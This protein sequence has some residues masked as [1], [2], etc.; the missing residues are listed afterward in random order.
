MKLM[1]MD[2]GITKKILRVRS[3]RRGD[4]RAPHKPLLLLYAL[5]KLQAGQSQIVFAEAENDLRDLLDDFGP[6]RKKNRPEYPFWRL[7][8]DHVWQIDLLV[9]VKENKSG[10]VG[11]KDLVDAGAKGFFT[12]EVINYFRENPKKIKHLVEE[13]LVAN[14]PETI[15]EDILQAVGLD[16]DGNGETGIASRWPKFREK[17][18]QAYGYRCA[19]CGFDLRMGHTP[20]ALEAA[21]IKWHQAGGPD[22]EVNGL[23]LCALHHNLFDRGTFTLSD[24][25]EV[26]VSDKA[27]GSSLVLWLMQYHGKKLHYPQSARYT[28]QHEYLSWHIREVFQG[29]YIDL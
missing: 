7:Q 10:D 18:L 19:V 27:N 14:F 23:A 25:L 15:H 1:T 4:V 13:I 16:L 8:K 3:W 11:R 24:K 17:V 20:V 26:L 21:H 29:K 28:P 5:A 22:V 12:A 6:P 2:S 9:P